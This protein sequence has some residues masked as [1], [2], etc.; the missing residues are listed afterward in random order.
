MTKRVKLVLP[1]TGGTA[2]VPEAQVDKFVANGWVR[3]KPVTVRKKSS[4]KAEPKST[5]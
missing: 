3:P 1:A 4:G 2:S 5:K